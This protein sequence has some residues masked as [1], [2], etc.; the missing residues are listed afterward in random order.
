MEIMDAAK[1]KEPT[2]E[3]P[4]KNEQEEAGAAKP[5]RRAGA[6]PPAGRAADRKPKKPWQDSAQPQKRAPAGPVTSRQTARQ[7]AE[8]ELPGA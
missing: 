6:R 2:I 1:E 8:E 4:S 5:P 3:V 7:D